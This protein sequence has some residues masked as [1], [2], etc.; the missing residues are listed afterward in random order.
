MLASMPKKIWSA[1]YGSMILILKSKAWLWT[2]KLPVC[3]SRTASQIIQQTKKCP[4]S[5]CCCNKGGVLSDIVCNSPK[6]VH[7]CVYK[8]Y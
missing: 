6:P 7:A 1:G 4:T 2:L 8:H 5:F 3:F